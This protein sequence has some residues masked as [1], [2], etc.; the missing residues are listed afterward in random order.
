MK[1]W[2]GKALSSADGGALVIDRSAT[3][4]RISWAIADME[5]ADM[6]KGLIT[7][8]QTARTNRYVRALQFFINGLKSLWNI[9]CL[10]LRC[11]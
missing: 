10:T 5:I 3:A 7:N 11:F 6:V 8:K 4:G 2:S 9:A 1:S